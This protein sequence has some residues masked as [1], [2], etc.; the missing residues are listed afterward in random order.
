MLQKNQLSSLPSWLALC[1]SLS[2][3]AV[4]HYEPHPLDA[5]AGVQELGARSLASPGLKSHIAS[6][7]RGR[8]ALAWPPAAW[9]LELLTLVVFHFNADLEAARARLAAAD[10][11]VTT[12]G[13]RPN[14][15]LQLP[16]QRTLNPK[17]GESSWTLGLALDIPV[18]THGK[19][20]YRIAEADSR[21]AAARL[22][23]ANLAW[24][25][26]SQ[27]R[28]QLLVLESSTEKTRLLEQQVELDR[29][30]VALQQKRL[31]QGYVAAR[32][33][34]QQQLALIQSNGELLG[35]RKEAGAARARLAG[36]LGLPPGALDGV[37]L[38][39]AGFTATDPPLP[40]RELQSQALLNRADVLESLASYEASQAALQLE[41]ARQYPDLHLG[42][43]YTLDQGARKA[44][45]DFS[46]IELPVFHRNEGPIAEA[47][48]RREEAAAKVRQAQAR[49]WSELD[50]GLTGYRIAREALD[51]ADR[52][53]TLQQKQLAAR[54]RAFDLGEEDRAALELDRKTELA[55]RLAAFDAAVQVQQALGRIED[56]IQR[57]LSTIDKQ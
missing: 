41:V 14:P 15:T 8:Q 3:C 40:L 48:A 4:Q 37:K 10:A 5:A 47:G 36:L 43:G 46:G 25:L 50:A 34:N 44:G 1:L 19:R 22:Q 29:S 32:D 21:A 16:L 33:L 27:L 7:Y 30:L 55:A 26:R 39:L 20:D 12:A 38:D 52:Q 42:P 53:R 18:E 6:K 57:P 51:Q 28:E 49:A 45:F 31:A 17:D 13:Q 24:S 56:A 35:A 54:Q 9:D 2:A 11:A 23:L